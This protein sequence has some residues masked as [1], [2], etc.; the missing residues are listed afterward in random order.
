MSEREERQRKRREIEKRRR[1]KQ[2]ERERQVRRAKMIL[3]GSV[4]AVV[5]VIVGI[6]ALVRA[7]AKADM[8]DKSSNDKNIEVDPDKEAAV[9]PLCNKPYI[10]AKAI[11]NAAQKETKETKGIQSENKGFDVSRFKEEFKQ[12]SLNYETQEIE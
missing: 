9:C 4:A 5:L 1:Q 11:E 10:V 12:G 2:L 8:N 3:A 6:V 7:S